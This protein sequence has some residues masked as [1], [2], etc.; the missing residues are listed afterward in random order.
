M[1][2]I[3][4]VVHP[5]GLDFLNQRKVVMLRDRGTPG[6]KKLSFAKIALMVRNLQ[7]KP[8]TE[9][10]ARRVYN[11][12]NLKKGRVLNQYRKCGRSPWKLP[13]R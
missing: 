7:G 9:A 1:P 13:N 5:A 10:T 4:E 8:T 12:F 11:E 6:E 2:V 3:S